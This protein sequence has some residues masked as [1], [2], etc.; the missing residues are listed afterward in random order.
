MQVLHSKLWKMKLPMLQLI[1]VLV[2]GNL[3]MFL[4]VRQE[5][6]DLLLSLM[7]DHQIEVSHVT[8]TCQSGDH[9]LIG[10]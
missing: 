6:T 5:L 4:S 1:Q 8:I 2:F 3:F 7:H 9:H 10:A